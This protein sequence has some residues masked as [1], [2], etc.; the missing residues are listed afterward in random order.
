M[1]D[2]WRFP[3]G[4]NMIK[5][6]KKSDKERFDCICEEIRKYLHVEHWKHFYEFTDDNDE[7]SDGRG[8]LAVFHPQKGRRIHIEIQKDFW[9]IGYEE[10]IRTLLHEHVHV[11]QNGYLFVEREIVRLAC[12]SSE[13]KNWDERFNHENEQSTDHMEAILFDLLK[14]RLLKL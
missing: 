10:Q 1:R 13:W 5:P 6:L 4:N 11:M 8:T 3:P 12:H 2:A 7:D 14:E 9:T